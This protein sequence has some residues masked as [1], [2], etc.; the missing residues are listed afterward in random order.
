M[1]SNKPSSNPARDSGAYPCFL[2][3]NVL[4]YCDDSG[5][6]VKQQK[7]L[8]IVLGHRRK[9]T[10]VVS[11]QVLQEYFA[12]ATRKLGLDPDLAKQKV[13]VYARFRVV[14]PS[15]ADLLAAVDLHRLHKLS[16]WDALI[17]RS[18]KQSGCRVLLSEDMQHDQVIGG[19]RIVN[20]F[21]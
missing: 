17:L 21:I 12:N 16:I 7:A 4:L 6:P 9:G 19:V 15:V 8:E 14:E 5:S 11:L 1:S 18:A 13:E 20:P 2:D 3:T 10:G